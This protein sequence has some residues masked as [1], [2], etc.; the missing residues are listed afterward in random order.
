MHSDYDLGTILVPANDL[1]RKVSWTMTT[2]LPG[3]ASAQTHKEK[4]LPFTD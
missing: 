4:T 2:S 1:A 3:G